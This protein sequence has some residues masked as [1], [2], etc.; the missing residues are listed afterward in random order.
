MCIVLLDFVQIL[1]LWGKYP[2]NDL[3][4]LTVFAALGLSGVRVDGG[5]RLVHPQGYAVEQDHG[6]RQSLKPT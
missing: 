1:I 4:D 6:H 5:T 2:V 3:E